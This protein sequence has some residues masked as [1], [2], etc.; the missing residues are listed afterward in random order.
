MELKICILVMLLGDV[1]TIK[2]ENHR[3]RGTISF[4]ILLPLIVT[5]INPWLFNNILVPRY[6]LNMRVNRI[7][8]ES[9][10]KSEN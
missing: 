5:L 2:S 10:N 7:E 3:F 9:W 4:S 1:A 6:K 8:M